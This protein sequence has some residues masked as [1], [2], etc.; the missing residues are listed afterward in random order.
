VLQPPL[1]LFAEDVTLC[2]PFFTGEPEGKAVTER[3]LFAASQCRITALCF[4]PRT[5]R[6]SRRS[7]TKPSKAMC[8]R[9]LKSSR[10]TTSAARS[11]SSRV[12]PAV[13]PVASVYEERER[14]SDLERTGAMR[15][16]FGKTALV[17][18]TSGGIGLAIARRFADD[19][20]RIYLT[21]ARASSKQR[22]GRPAPARSPCRA[23]SR[24]APT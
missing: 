23:T 7:S 18:G 8:C 15:P 24:R 1:V 2:S 17:T 21:G 3:V 11:G 20:A 10:S 14:H 12:D 5:S 16:M 6:R 13:D 22:P 4:K 19:G 9:S